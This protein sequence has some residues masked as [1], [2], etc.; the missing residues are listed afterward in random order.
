M[1][2]RSR[3]PRKLPRS[4]RGVVCF[5]LASRRAGRCVF[6]HAPAGHDCHACPW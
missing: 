4:W 1:S 3:M 6:R 2:C 5:R